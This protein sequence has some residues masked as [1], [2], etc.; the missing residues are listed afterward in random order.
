MC[1]RGLPIVRDFKPCFFKQSALFIQIKCFV[2]SN[3]VTLFIQTRL[4]ETYPASC[5][6]ESYSIGILI[7][8]FVSDICSRHSI[9]CYFVSLF[10][11][12]SLIL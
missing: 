9:L 12:Y 1:V 5:L 7:C 8:L 6:S 3:K 4:A 2:Y 11:V 10:S